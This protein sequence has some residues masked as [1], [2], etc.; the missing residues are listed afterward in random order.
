M[1]FFSSMKNVMGI[2][3]YILYFINSLIHGKK[4]DGIKIGICYTY[5]APKNSVMM[6][7]ITIIDI[8]YTIVSKL[9]VII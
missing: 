2:Y 9:L 1:D 8:Y 4:I 3:F 5:Y 7:T 6:E